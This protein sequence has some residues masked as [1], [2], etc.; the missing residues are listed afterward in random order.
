MAVPNEHFATIEE[1]DRLAQ[2]ML[3]PHVQV[4]L[5]L[6][7][8][9]A[10]AMREAAQ[11]L[12]NAG[13]Y[14]HEQGRY[15]E[16]EPLYQRALAIREQQLGPL[17]PDTAQSLN[18]LAGLYA[19]Q[20][21]YEQ[22]EPLYQRALAIWEQVLGPEHPHTITVLKNYAALLQ[23]MNRT[24]EAFTLLHPVQAKRAENVQTDS[25]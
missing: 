15:T 14:L 19:D 13:Y 25:V 10:L 8:Q 20:G 3:L 23:E 21:K 12:N 4:C 16:C 11:P 2:E 7:D 9:Y 22:A 6:L 1:T 17:H 5:V 24:D 18:N